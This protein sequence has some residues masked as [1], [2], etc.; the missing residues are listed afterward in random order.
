MGER[1]EAAGIG[2]KAS[3]LAAAAAAEL[4]AD[5]A[6]DKPPGSDMQGYLFPDT[7]IFPIGVTSAM[8]VQEM[9]AT[10]DRR[11]TP[12]LRAAVRAHG[13]NLHQA[14]TLASIVEREA[15]LETDRPLIASV[16]Y[17][18]LGDGV[19]LDADPTT[20]FAAALDPLSVLEY[21]YWKKD[22]TRADLENPSP[23]NTYLHAGLPPGP[24]ANPSLASIQAVANPATTRY[25]Y[26]VADAKKADGSH[27][28]A[29]TLDQHNANVARVGS[30]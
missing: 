29:E 4:P 19:K 5:F 24:I 2:T 10:L 8:L 3:F 7:Y 12:D 17:N 16:F 22:L 30:P 18:R 20:Q 15:V 28:F 27:V 14:L 6:A 13:L 25:F 11:F 23:Y 9:V 1:A 26:F 21:G